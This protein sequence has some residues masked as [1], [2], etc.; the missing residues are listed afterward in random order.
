MRVEDLDGP[1]TRPE[2]VL[3]NLEELRWL[4][5]DWDE[6][7]DVGGA[8]APYLQSLRSAAYAAAFER[9][10]A[11]GTVFPCYLSRK[12]IAEASSAPHGAPSGDRPGEPFGAGRPAG[13]ERVYGEAERALSAGLARE[14]ATAGASPSWRFAVAA[15]AVEFTDACAGRVRLDLPRD[16]GH[17]VVRRSDGLW[18]Y[19]LAV[20]VDDG[21]MGITEVVRGADLLT[22]TGAQLAL[23]AA[24][25][26]PP[27][28]FA[29][30]GLLVDAGGERLA[31]RRG[32]LTLHELR[33]AGV[34]P[35]RVL[36]L[37]ASTI[38]VMA[39]PA[40]L[41][42][43]ELRAAFDPERH[44]CGGARLSPEELTWLHAQ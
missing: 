25:G 23:Y 19:Q 8:H 13:A 20:V 16:V 28:A 41:D 24:L 7:P 33:H 31:K 26:A 43:G 38:G 17:F 44:G 22:S 11:A 34:R 35:E 18:A 3:G 21:A 5:L 37:L 12:D 4:G 6:G 42:V 36:G 30:V 15:A 39:R 14:K 1:R 2:A 40:E 29:H 9:L 10:Q 32:S 27:P